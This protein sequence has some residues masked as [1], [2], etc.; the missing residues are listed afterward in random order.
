LSAKLPSIPF[1]SCA[2]EGSPLVSEKK[3]FES[4]KIVGQQKKENPAQEKDFQPQF[5][6]DS[7][8]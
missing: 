1:R 2:P 6:T 5:E 8:R 4:Q 7:H 3:I